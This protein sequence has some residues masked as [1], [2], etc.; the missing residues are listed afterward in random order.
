M[1]QTQSNR[2]PQP[3]LKVHPVL[4]SVHRVDALPRRLGVSECWALSENGIMGQSNDQNRSTKVVGCSRT[5]QVCEGTLRYNT[6]CPE[7]EMLPQKVWG[8]QD[9]RDGSAG[10]GLKDP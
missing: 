9:G 7:P 4:G 10:L 2:A 1:S 8:L 5:V 3:Q 6:P